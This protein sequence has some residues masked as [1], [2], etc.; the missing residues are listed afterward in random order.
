MAAAAPSGDHA[1]YG[2]T[3]AAGTVAD[4][5]IVTL[6][7]PAAAPAAIADSAR[8]LARAYGGS[9]LH[10]YT[11]VLHGFA[12]HLNANAAA[13][14]AAAPGVAAVEPV[15]TVKASDTQ[16]NP[17]SWGLD[18]IDQTSLPLDHTYTYANTA[19]NVTAYV[20][21]SGIDATDTDFGGRASVGID[22]LPPPD[23]S[24]GFDCD[25]HGTHVAGTIGG[26]AYGVAKAVKLVAVRVLNCQGT[27]TDAQVIAG[28]DWVAQDVVAHPGVPA[29]ANVSLNGFASTYIDEATNN[30]IKTGV[31]V[32]VAA[33]N[34]D[35]ND[36][37]ADGVACDYSPARLPVAIT[38]QFPS[39]MA[40]CT[41]Q[42]HIH[43]SA[44]LR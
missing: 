31:T 13:R 39:A 15:R 9:L 21:D 19:S 29:V 5:Y 41:R 2:G 28:L 33:G 6:K 37:S 34:H 30:L 3:P 8:G 16:I 40:T 25:G 36:P 27:G 35:P 44:E 17:P 12:I 20:V 11:R 1:R 32:V 26:T 10:T 42:A 38:A 22:V 14:L 24:D 18:R 7:G 23:W 43:L 4:Q